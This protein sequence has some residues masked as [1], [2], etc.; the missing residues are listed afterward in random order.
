MS[1]MACVTSVRCYPERASAV[2]RR[3][4]HILLA[5]AASFR[6]TFNPMS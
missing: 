2:E 1:R 3:A 6:D 4:F 5:T